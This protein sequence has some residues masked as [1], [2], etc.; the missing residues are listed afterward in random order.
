MVGRWSSERD[1]S[2]R[3]RCR[4]TALP[5]S[6]QSRKVR[7]VEHQGSTI[8]RP[9]EPHISSCDMS[10]CCSATEGRTSLWRSSR[11][12]VQEGRDAEWAGRKRWP[13][14][15]HKICVD[16]QFMFGIKVPTKAG[17][18]RG[19]RRSPW[20]GPHPPAHLPTQLYP[21]SCSA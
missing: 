15:P 5:G 11:R 18:R 6:T 2:Q 14:Q 4:E 3:A 1:T 19:W 13:A 16:V 10:P 12:N 20:L 7:Q 9:K 21:C 17:R 8:K